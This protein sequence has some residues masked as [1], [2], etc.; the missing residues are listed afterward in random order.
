[1]IGSD[2]LLTVENFSYPLFFKDFFGSFSFFFIRKL[3]CSNFTRESRVDES[4]FSNFFERPRFDPIS[5]GQKLLEQRPPLFRLHPVVQIYHV[6][7]AGA[8]EV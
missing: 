6:V 8:S 5:L 4:F 3:I 7:P 1:M 2:P